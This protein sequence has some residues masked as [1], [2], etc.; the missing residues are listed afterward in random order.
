MNNARLKSGASCEGKPTRI[1]SK[2]VEGIPHPALI[3]NSFLSD[4]FSDPLW[5][6]PAGLV[7]DPVSLGPKWKVIVGNDAASLW[8]D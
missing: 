3:L 5:L 1:E 8:E 2:S 6:L 7:N 4:P